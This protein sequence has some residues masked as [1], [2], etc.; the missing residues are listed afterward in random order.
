MSPATT[1]TLSPRAIRRFRWNAS[2]GNHE[3]P[4]TRIANPTSPNLFEIMGRFLPLQG[5]SF[6]WQ[7]DGNRK[8]GH[9]EDDPDTFP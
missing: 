3:M 5:S 7:G 2:R 4:R 1:R 6:P 8:D 9:G